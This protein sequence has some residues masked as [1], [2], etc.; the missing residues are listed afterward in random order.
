MRRAVA[1]A[2]HLLRLL[3]VALLLVVAVTGSA[4]RP[5]TL[6]LTKLETA[7]GYDLPQG[8]VWILVL[9]SDQPATA[10]VEEGATD[11]IQ[12]LG[13]D[14][15]TGAAA[16]I[17]IS[18]DTWVDLPGG[19]QDRINTVLFRSGGDEQAVA[20]VVNELVGIRA[21]Y[22]LVTGG[23]G[24]LDMVD[25]LGGVTVDSPVA[26]TADDD[27]TLHVVKGENT[28]NA[29]QALDFATSR[30]FPVQGDLLRSKNHQALL[31]GL[32]EQFQKRA[33]KRGFIETMGLSA[34]DS[35]DPGNATP[36]DLY[37]LLNALMGIDPKKVS[38][39]CVVPGTDQTIDGSQVII[40]DEATAQR[41]GNDVRDDAVY[42][43]PC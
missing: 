41:Y 22:V 32:L 38:P 15:D 16:A 5:A 10:Q 9:G 35:I 37:R 34:I 24:F 23:E 21:S 27:P 8:V 4:E 7:A 39:S 12:L 11:A 40:P 43:E 31:L 13:I 42:D 3:P 2:R 30:N 29:Q 19:G 1:V 33:A 14:V 25:T 26:F 36:L 17:G 6:S 28:F 18:R 20:D